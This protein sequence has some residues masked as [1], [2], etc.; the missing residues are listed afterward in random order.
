MMITRSL[1][2]EEKTILNMHA[3]NSR[4]SKYMAQKLTELQGKTGDLKTRLSVF[5][6]FSTQTISKDTEE[7][8]STKN[9]LDPTDTYGLFHPTTAE[10]TF[11]Q[12]YT[13]YSS[14]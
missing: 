1:L 13:E 9:Q 5:G 4:T 7:L 2:Q 6:K 14:K 11:S 12:V 10:P 8:K 3:P